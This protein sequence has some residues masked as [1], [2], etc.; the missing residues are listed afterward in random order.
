[1]R[2]VRLVAAK[3]KVVLLPQTSSKQTLHALRDWDLWG[4][5][6]VCLTLSM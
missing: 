3:L 5:L 2:D 6:M 1:M 4:P